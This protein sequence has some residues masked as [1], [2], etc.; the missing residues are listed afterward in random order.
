MRAMPTY[1]TLEPMA[2]FDLRLQA[3]ISTRLS[4]P[5]LHDTAQQS[6][7]QPIRN[8]GIGFRSMELAVPAAAS[9]VRQM[10]SRS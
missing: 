10:F 1:A 7:Q 8:G 6:L 5:P 3:A 2:D 4:L 9:N